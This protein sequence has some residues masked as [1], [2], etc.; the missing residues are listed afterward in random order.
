MTMRKTLLFLLVLFISAMPL[1]SSV[2]AEKTKETHNFTNSFTYKNEDNKNEDNTPPTGEFPPLDKPQT[3]IKG[4][5][6]IA[7][8]EVGINETDIVYFESVLLDIKNEYGIEAEPV[9]ISAHEYPRGSIGK[10]IFDD[11]IF[12][13]AE[14][15]IY[16]APLCDMLYASLYGSFENLY[17]N[18]SIDAILKDSLSF[19]PLRSYL[20]CGGFIPSYYEEIYVIPY[21]KNIIGDIKHNLS[22]GEFINIGKSFGEVSFV[23]HDGETVRA[24]LS[25]VGFFDNRDAL[26]EILSDISVL[27]CCATERDTLNEG[28]RGGTL[29]FGA[30]TTLAEA[31]NFR[32]ALGDFLGIMAVPCENGFAYSENLHVGAVSSASESK[33]LALEFIDALSEFDFAESLFEGSDFYESEKNLISSI[34]ADGAIGTDID[35]E[36]VMNMI[37]GDGDFEKTLIVNAVAKSKFNMP[38]PEEIAEKNYEKEKA[39]YYAMIKQSENLEN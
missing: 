21:N 22:L 1:V 25:G 13:R 33:E 32:D 34:T 16:F 28:F 39:Y 36:F 37:F 8:S 27:A 23:S 35:K 31:E 3:E 11:H 26:K 9:Y 17:G 6:K 20:F 4:K 19:A 24:L 30:V 7:I 2:K 5:I 15:D 12:E 10:K 29:P 14:A 18:E 38:S